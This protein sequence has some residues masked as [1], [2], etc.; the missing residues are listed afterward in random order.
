M[1]FPPRNAKELFSRTEL[2]MISRKALN[3]NS[4]VSFV[5]KSPS[6]KKGKSVVA[7]QDGRVPHIE[8]TYRTVVGMMVPQSFVP[9]LSYFVQLR[10]GYVR[11]R[12]KDT[13]RGMRLHSIIQEPVQQIVGVLAGVPS[14][15][16]RQT[17]CLCLQT[18]DVVYQLIPSCMRESGRLGVCRSRIEQVQPANMNRGASAA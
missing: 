1:A 13:T 3:S 5:S 18:E 12:R 4:L 2:S 6:C 7:Q 14:R 8:P 9:D 17:Q 11:W 15:V 16:N 10:F